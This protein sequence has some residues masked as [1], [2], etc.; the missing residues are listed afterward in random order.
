MKILIL[1]AT[2]LVGRQVLALALAD[3]RIEQVIAPTRRNL[4]P[5]PKLVNPIAPE[6][7]T[8]APDAAQ[9]QVDAVI[10]AM[11]STMRKAGSKA[12]FRHADYGIPLAFATQAYRHGAKTLAL[13][14]ATGASPSVPIFYLRVKGEVERDMRNIGFPSLTIVRPGMI[15]GHREE[16][17]LAERMMFP[18]ARIL[19]P[20]LPKGLWI[21]PAAHIAA[22]LIQAAVAPKP[23]LTMVIS[24]DLV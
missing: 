7:E 8:L 17:R 24:R 21:N 18:V 22:A 13:V 9:W 15:G 23:G 20:L 10:C 4:A 11:G 3:A 12:A 2:G 6:L 14:S 5:D 19:R 1:G 16:F